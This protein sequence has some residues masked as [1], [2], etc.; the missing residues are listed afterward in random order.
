ME[1]VT[2]IEDEE[3]GMVRTCALRF[4]N[5]VCEKL[6]LGGLFRCYLNGGEVVKRSSVMP[7]RA[8]QRL[9]TPVINRPKQSPRPRAR[10]L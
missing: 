6:G 9:M 10:R 1:L 5:G 3:V 8:P 2:I 7:S 4:C